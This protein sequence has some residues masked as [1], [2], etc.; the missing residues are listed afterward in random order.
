MSTASPGSPSSPSHEAVEDH[1]VGPDREVGGDRL[2][3]AGVALLA[4]IATFGATIFTSIPG[5]AIG[6]DTNTAKVVGTLV[7]SLLQNLVFV[8]VPILIVGLSIGG[9]RRSD[10]G[11]RVPPRPLRVLG[12]V[13]VAFVAYI[14]LSALLGAA[15][16]VGDEQDDLPGKLGADSSVLAGIAIGLAVTVLAPIGEETLLRGIVYPGLRN[17]VARFAPAPVAIGAAALIDGLIFGALHLGGSKAIFLPILALFGVV[18]CLLY[19][20]SGSLYASILLHAT[21][22]TIAMKVALDWSVLGA[23]ALWVSAL[24]ILTLL[25]LA[26][27]AYERGRDARRDAAGPRADAAPA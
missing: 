25:M 8:G 22:N 11:W 6:D 5:I 1:E 20:F 15:L 12:M 10:I 3:G 13:A 18:L 9:L 27:R 26:A 2:W 7:S 19:Q 14:V 23:I 24:T 21:N 17:S 16:G 4:L